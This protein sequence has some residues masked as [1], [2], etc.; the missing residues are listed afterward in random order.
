MLSDKFSNSSR[1]NH[2]IKG[3]DYGVIT[4]SLLGNY[5]VIMQPS[6]REKRKNSR[7]CLVGILLVFSEKSQKSVNLFA[8]IKKK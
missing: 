5:R 7:F 2:D 1:P 8:Y 3:G 4:G 6:S